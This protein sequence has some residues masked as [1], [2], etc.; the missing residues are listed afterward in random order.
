MA[1]PISGTFTQDQI[2]KL[3][4]ISNDKANEKRKASQE[5][6]KDAFLK[7]M[8]A[9]LQNQNPLEPVDNKDYMA[10][11]AQFSSVEQLSN[12]VGSI[13]GTNE[14]NALISTQLDELKEAV[15]KSGTTEE[16]GKLLE[17]NTKILEE[18]MKM[19]QMLTQYF[20][21]E[22]SVEDTDLFELLAND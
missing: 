19:N 1:F 10:Q 9:Q 5:L 11:M 17:Q 15:E 18:L 21:S 4:V 2:E 16:S 13:E 7:L 20:E 8:M 22:T 3:N 14:L 6:D 12:I